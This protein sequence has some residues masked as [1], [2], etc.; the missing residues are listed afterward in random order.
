MKSWKSILVISVIMTISSLVW[1]GEVVPPGDVPA[2]DSQ[3]AMVT[4]YM[5]AVNAKDRGKLEAVIHPKCLAAITDENR[6]LINR[7]LSG[8]FNETIPADHKLVIKLVR[9]DQLDSL[10]GYASFPVPPTH[11]IQINWF[12]AK[13]TLRGRMLF[14]LK[15]NGKWLDVIAIPTSETVQRFRAQQAG[16]ASGGQAKSPSHP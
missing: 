12:P 9:Q 8:E 16:P 4:A 13:N 11:T 6:D 7:I 5:A 3:Q 1:A 10:K 15:E 14:V 2:A